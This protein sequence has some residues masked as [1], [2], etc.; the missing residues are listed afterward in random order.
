MYFLVDYDRQSGELI[1]VTSFAPEGRVLAQ[2][3]RLELEICL[4]AQGVEREVVILEAEDEASLR[5][6]HRRY[7]EDVTKLPAMPSQR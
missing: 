1:S 4:N 5:V 3:A 7:F 6:T 2:V